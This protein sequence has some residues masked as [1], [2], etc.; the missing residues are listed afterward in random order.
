MT[1]IR[2]AVLC[3]QPGRYI[4]WPS[5]AQA[6]NGDLL[7]VFSGDRQGH[8]SPDGKVQLVRSH[9]GGQAWEAAVTVFSTPI[10]D[11]DSGVITTAQGTVL[12]SWFTG[13][14]GGPWQGHWTVRSEDHG[15]T[16]DQPVRSPVTAPHGPVQLRDG[17]LLFLGQRPHCSHGAPPDWNGD[18]AQ[19]PYRVALAHSRDDGRSWNDLATFPVPA[20]EQMLSYDEAHLV[21]VS[22]GHL[23]ALFRDCNGRHYLRQSTS[24][25]GG[26]TWSAPQQ[27]PIRGLPPHLIELRDG[28]LLATYAKRW[29]PYGVYTCRS[30]DHGQSWDTA[31]EIRLS[32]APDSDLGYP[33]SLQ[34]A[35]DSIWTVY[36]QVDQVGEKPCLMGTHWRL[37]ST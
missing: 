27:T 28:A 3:K 19:S 5:I 14:Y 13:P 35:D 8:I 37:Y 30:H 22:A 6:A 12:V 23:L 21:E 7:V 15:H 16:W 17:R 2:T 31:S 18:P 33:A 34:L 25:D 1:I 20:D 36:Y 29:P 4:G 11:R 9:D 24:R 26:S 10:D 32:T